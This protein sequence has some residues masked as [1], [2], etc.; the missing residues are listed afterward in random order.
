MLCF[1]FRMKTSINPMFHNAL[2]LCFHLL[3]GEGNSNRNPL[4]AQ[5]L[6][7]ISSAL[8]FKVCWLVHVPQV[9][10]SVKV[11]SSPH[12]SQCLHVT[13]LLDHVQCVCLCMFCVC[14]CMCV[15]KWNLHFWVEQPS[16]GWSPYTALC[17]TYSLC[18]IYWAVYS[19]CVVCIVVFST[20]R[21]L[22]SV[23]CTL[24][25]T[26]LSP[27]LKTSQFRAVKQNIMLA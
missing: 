20:Q 12:V 2:M 16:Q 26:K 9:T 1:H 3:N 5:F 19:S 15:G 11:K 22:L 7:A 25:L 27:N 4:F 13:N 23:Q 8:M 21:L 10:C 14:L 17:Y 24:F 18:T 6:I